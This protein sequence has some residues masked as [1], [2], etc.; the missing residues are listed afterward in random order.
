[1]KI[2]QGFISNSSS[3]SFIVGV[4]KIEDKEKFDIIKNDYIKV[5]KVGDI[6][7]NWSV[8]KNDRRISVESFQ[9]SV[10]IYMEH[11]TEEDYIAIINISNNEGDDDFYCNDD[12][13]IDYDIDSDFF[14]KDQQELF[15]IFTEKNGLSNIDLTYGAGRNG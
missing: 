11:L 6:K 8:N 14:D 9:T 10:D 1:M 15:E 5:L 3:S 4:A 13:D 7:N 12:Y 2:R